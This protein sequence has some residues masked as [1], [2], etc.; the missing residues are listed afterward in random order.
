MVIQNHAIKNY[1]KINIKIFLSLAILILAVSSCKKLDRPLLGDYTKDANPP[2]GP[3]NFYAAFDGTTT[4]PLMNAVDSIKATFPSVNPFTT[5]AGISGK[6]VLGVEG[7]AIYYPGTNDFNKV[8][9]FSIALW[10]KN[11]AAAGRTEFLFSLVDDSYGWHHSAAFVLVENQTSTNATM[12]FGLM[13]QWLEGTFQKPLFDGNWHQIVY[14]Y[15][16]TTSK[17]TYYFDGALV[18]GMNASQTDVKNSGAPRGAIDFSKAYSLILGGWNKHAGAQ[19][20]GDDWIKNYSG[21][22]DQFRLY[23]KALNASEV[24]TLYASKK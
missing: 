23:K 14:S 2:G 20:P 3:L 21:A 12:K 6:A 9:S 16:Q 8:T 1:M 22:M 13:D 19:G 24:A 5:T 11:V 4:N 17:M 10:L 7:K 18:D 15:D